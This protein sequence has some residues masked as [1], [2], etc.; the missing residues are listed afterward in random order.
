MNDLR[1]RVRLKALGAPS[2]DL[3]DLMNGAFQN[4]GIKKYK[5]VFQNGSL[6][7]KYYSMVLQSPVKGLL[8]FSGL[9][10]LVSST[11]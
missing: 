10:E 6:R 8:R 4:P 3:Q 1:S 2:R 5:L 9:L 11:Y 7:K